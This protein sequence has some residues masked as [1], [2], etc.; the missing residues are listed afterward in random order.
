MCQLVSP[1]Y[2]QPL[3]IMFW[4]LGCSLRFSFVALTTWNS[5]AQFKILL[6]LSVVDISPALNSMLHVSLWKQITNIVFNSDGLKW[7]LQAD[8]LWFINMQRAPLLLLKYLSNWVRVIP[9]TQQSDTYYTT[10]PQTWPRFISKITYYS[11][12]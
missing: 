6:T 12:Y 7:F 11:K 1:F 8:L 5:V 3:V 10:V 4:S 9:T 2:G